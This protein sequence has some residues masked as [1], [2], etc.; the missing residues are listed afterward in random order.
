MESSVLKEALTEIE[1][2]NQD[3]ETLRLAIAREIHLKDQL[4]REEDAE[5]RGMG[6]GIEKGLEVGE[7]R[8]NREIVLN[9]YEENI[10]VALIAN[11][12]KIPFEKVEEIIKSVVQ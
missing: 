8:R 2:L 9:M 1:R 5:L 12:T 7:E 11:L 3:S 6:K 10:S 4:Q